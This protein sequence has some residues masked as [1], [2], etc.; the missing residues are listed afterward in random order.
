MREEGGGIS[1]AFA[2]IKSRTAV[3]SP[4]SEVAEMR[5]AIARGM[6]SEGMWGYRWVETKET[7]VSWEE[8]I[9][10]ENSVFT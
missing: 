3:S 4:A 5:L 6:M 2:N 8:I 7:S 10:M 1:T 9:M